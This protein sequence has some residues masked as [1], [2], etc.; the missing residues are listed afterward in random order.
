MGLGLVH[1]IRD[2]TENDY[3]STTLRCFVCVALILA[4]NF[5]VIH[6]YYFYSYVL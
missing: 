3:S 4:T 1:I 2:Q 5:Y 6:C